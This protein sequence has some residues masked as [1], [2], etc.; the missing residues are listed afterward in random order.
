M[1]I[2]FYRNFQSLRY[3]CC[4][5]RGA[6]LLCGVTTSMPPA[7]AQEI[8]EPTVTVHFDQPTGTL[9]GFGISEAFG[10][11]EAVRS[12]PPEKRM[13]VLNLLFDSKTG[14]NFR[15]LRLGINTDSM[16]VQKPPSKPGQTPVYSFDGSDGSQVWMAREAMRYGVR[17]FTAA[18]WTAPAY[19]KNN[20]NVVG[21]ALCGV[22]EVTCA[23]G[24][25]RP[26]FARYLLQD[27]Q[28]YRTLGIPVESLSFLNEPDIAVGYASMS[29]TPA[30]AIDFIKVLGPLA[31]RTLPDLKLACCDASKWST[32]KSFAEAL[33]ADPEAAHYISLYTAHQYGA[34]ATEPLPTSKPVWM[35]EWSSGAS[36]FQQRWDCGGCANNQDGMSLAHDILQAFAQGNIRAYIYWWGV[37]DGAANL[38]QI[39]DGSYTVGRRFYAVAGLS[40]FAVQGA[41]RVATAL[42]RDLIDAVG[43]QNPDGSAVVCVLNRN[44]AAIPMHIDVKGMQHPFTAEAMFTDISNSLAPISLQQEDSTFDVML[45]RRSMLTVVLKR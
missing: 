26:D 30:Q 33:E 45:P 40:R 13:E 36:Q 11:A 34:H 27:V 22:P 2:L 38:I 24:D 25:W 42:N 3:H 29:F 19:M 14:A 6:L 18:A 12:L 16:L 9:D 41:R 5:L 44:T 4:C 23:S 39:K 8:A 31:Q 17:R 15:I 1:R 35:T 37:G 32:A 10:Q 28:S 21:G 7:F 43:F 20:G